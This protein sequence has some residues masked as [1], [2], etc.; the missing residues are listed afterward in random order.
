MKEQMTVCCFIE[1]IERKSSPFIL[2]PGYVSGSYTERPRG[3]YEDVSSF[4]PVVVSFSPRLCQKG[5]GL[6]SQGGNR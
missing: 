3:R 6:Q 1:D 4:R 5:G 2:L